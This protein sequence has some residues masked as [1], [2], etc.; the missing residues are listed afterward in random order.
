MTDQAIQINIDNFN[1]TRILTIGSS[2]PHLQR[3][4]IEIFHDCLSNNIKL[5]PEWTPRELNRTAD[6][7]SKI[8]DTDSWGI[9]RETF[10]F[11]N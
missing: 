7:Y 8:R 1:A 10:A 2:K 6:Y 3:L 9:D 5:I 11:I 4:A